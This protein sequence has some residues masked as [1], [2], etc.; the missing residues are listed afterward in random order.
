MTL[1]TTPPIGDCRSAGRG[2]LGGALSFLTARSTECKILAGIVLATLTCSAGRG[3]LG[4]N[5]L[6]SLTARSTDKV[7]VKL[8]L[9]TIWGCRSAG[10]GILG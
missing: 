9:A 10:R 7:K 6:N 5:A 8:L 3:I 2:N 1:T 4:C